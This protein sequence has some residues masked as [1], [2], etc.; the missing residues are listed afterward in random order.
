[1]SYEAHQPMASQTLRTSEDKDH[2]SEPMMKKT[3]LRTAKDVMDR[4][5]WENPS[6]SRSIMIGY[7]D[8]INGPMEISFQ[9]FQSIKNGG[10]IPEHRILYFRNVEA[11]SSDSRG[12]GEIVWDRAGRVDKIFTPEGDLRGDVSAETETAALQAVATMTRLA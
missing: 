7:D 9:K 4:L 1:M 11:S 3:K 10:D 2:Q 5:R 8:R 6:A 12:Y